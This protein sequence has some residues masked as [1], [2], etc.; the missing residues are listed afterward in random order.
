MLTM[1]MQLKCQVSHGDNCGRIT[2]RLINTSSCYMLKEKKA[3]CNDITEMQSE[4]IHHVVM[5]YCISTYVHTPIC[6]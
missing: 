5:N 4:V 3:N 6:T 2:G 1:A